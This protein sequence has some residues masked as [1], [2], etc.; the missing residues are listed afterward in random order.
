MTSNEKNQTGERLVTRE[1]HADS[2]L[3][4]SFP[5]LCAWCEKEG[6]ETI[7]GWIGVAHSHGICAAHR[8]AVIEE[9]ERIRQIGPI[10]RIGRI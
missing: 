5:V 1:P 3:V 7:L 2:S 8:A 4:T 10:G 9:A 6:R